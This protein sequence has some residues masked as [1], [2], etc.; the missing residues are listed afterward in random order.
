MKDFKEILQLIGGDNHA[1][2]GGS[3]AA[4][5]GAL[6]AST[7][8]KVVVKTVKKL[9]KSSEDKV[10][11]LDDLIDLN[12]ASSILSEVDDL[13][14]GFLDAGSLD[15]INLSHLIEGYINPCEDLEERQLKAA[16]APA[17]VK[18][19]AEKGI[20]LVGRI[21]AL[22]S[23]IFESDI[24]TAE[25]LF[26]A[27]LEGARANGLI[28]LKGSVTKNESFKKKQE[29]FNS[30]DTNG[31]LKIWA[32]DG[33]NRQELAGKAVGEN[34]LKEVAL[35]VDDFID[36]SGGSKPIF[37]VVSAKISKDSNAYVRGLE[38]ACSKV[39]MDMKHVDVNTEE[40]F[41]QAVDTFNKDSKVVGILPLQ[42][43]PAEFDQRKIALTLDENK[44]VDAMGAK[45][46]RGTMVP[47]TALAVMEI[48]NYYQIDLKGKMALV[49]GRSSVIGEPVSKLLLDADATVATVHSK[50]K[51]EDV[52]ALIKL[53]D[54]IVLA[55]GSYQWLK[56]DVSFAGKVIVDVAINFNQEGNMGGDLDPS[57]VK[58]LPLKYTPVPGGVGSVTTSMILRN[59]MRRWRDLHFPLNMVE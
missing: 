23:K 3:A 47:A 48:L 41:L 49:V 40:E 1:P 53:A 8:R 54:I 57:T 15:E 2:G 33:D 42:P 13:I 38:R 37:A 35:L 32:L 18:L 45:Y 7:L 5:C 24:V 16:A 50:S 51:V 31:Q 26:L 34:T 55:R 28:N 17:K 21:K 9:E 59:A 29:L 22:S 20:E 25:A 30:F 6:G 19:L 56:A 14:E 4:Y 52:K 58:G 12:D 10:N 27:A 44:D 39:G 11:R 43:L 46:G 36:V